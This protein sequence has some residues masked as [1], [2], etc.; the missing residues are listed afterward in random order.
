ML[1]LSL[2]SF[3]AET[4]NFCKTTLKAGLHGVVRDSAGKIVRRT[5]LGKNPVILDTNIVISLEQVKHFPELADG[6]R[7][8][9]ASKVHKMMKKRSSKTDESHVYI[10]ERTA[11][12]RFVGNPDNNN[13]S[14]PE[15][16]RIFEI[17]VSRSSNE[18]QSVLKRLESINLGQLKKNSENDREIVA[19][20]FFSKRNYK[21]DVPTFVTGD[22]GIYGPLCQLNPRC[23]SLGGDRKLIRQVF[24][25]GFDVSVT[26]GGVSRTIRIMPF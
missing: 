2:N 4:P 12:E 17:E 6:S 14:F 8:L 7:K 1:L 18:Y 21:D 15:G 23:L 11:K 9:W 16:T 25:D 3:A 10:A 20:L 19:D 5:P 26:T 13:I 22:A 24:Q